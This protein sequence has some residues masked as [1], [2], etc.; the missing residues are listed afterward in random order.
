MNQDATGQDCTTAGCSKWSQVSTAMD[1]V[2]QATDTNV[3]WGLVFFG[4]N[5]SC[6]VTSTPVVAVGAMNGQKVTM[7]FATNQP[8]SYTPTATAVDAAVTYMKTLKDTN[9]KYL[10]L[11]TDGLPNCGANSRQN[12]T[13]DDSPA[14]EAAVANARNAGFP[15]F[16]VG[17][18]TDSD[19]MATNTLNTMAVNGGFP[20]SGAATQYYS[21][22]D[23]ASLEGVLNQIVGMVAS[24]TIPLTN[25]PSNLTNV[26]VSAQGASGKPI[27]I[28]QDPA[29]GWSYTNGTMNVIKLNGSACDNLQNGTYSNV[30]FLY[31]CEGTTICI[32]RN[33]DGSCGD[34]P[35]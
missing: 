1:A 16:V 29:N 23:T 11:A 19:Q 26:A 31:A 28:K 13:A 8:S 22:S 15:T 30:Q 35:M 9:P 32:D 14:A 18:A 7:A 12:M 27:E 21:V 6:G 20:Q 5:S 2:V 10:L 17:I 25:V 3:N 34:H 33:P 24:C 4:T